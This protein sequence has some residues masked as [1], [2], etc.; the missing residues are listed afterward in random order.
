MSSAEKFTQG[1]KWQGDWIHL[2]DFA[3]F[4]KE[5]N[6]CDFLFDLL[7]RIPFTKWVFTLRMNNLLPLNLLP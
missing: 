2:I 6:F 7:Q 3:I 4:N 1:A 5:E